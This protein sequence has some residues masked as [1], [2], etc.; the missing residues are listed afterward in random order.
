[1]KPI[2][3]SRLLTATA[4]MTAFLGCIVVSAFA[5]DSSLLKGQ[6]YSDPVQLAALISTRSEPYILVDVRTAE[7]YNAGYIP[8]AINIPY[9][10]IARNPP[11]SDT[12]ALV[13]VYCASGRRSSMATA[14]L[15][16]LGY[17]RVVDFGSIKKWKG[18]KR[19]TT[20]PDNCPC[21][22]L[23][24]LWHPGDSHSSHA[25]GNSDHMQAVRTLCWQRT[26]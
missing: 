1:M 11:T 23:G 6:D 17:T 22:E 9:D 12:T 24:E 2:R 21:N 26:L 20:D 14:T 5:Q 15:K 18:P 16:G 4:S 10:Q 19:Q 13:I 7:E 3:L 8:T 25:F